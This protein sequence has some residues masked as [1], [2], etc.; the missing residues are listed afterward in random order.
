MNKQ[1]RVSAAIHGS[2]VDYV[3]Y[4][5]WY[6]FGTQFMPGE[7]AADLVTGFYERFDLDFIKVMNDYS[8]P[9]PAGLDRIRT[10][11]DWKRMKPAKPTEGGF[12][13]QL[14]LLNVVAQRVKSEAFFV[15]TIFDPFYVARRT[16]K[17]IIFDLLRSHPEEFKL[18]LEVITESL[19]NYV[20]AVLDTGAAG[21][22]LAVNGASTDLLS[23]EEFQ[24]FVKPY[25]LQVLEAAQ[26][27]GILNIVHIHGNNIL[28]DDMLDYPVHVLSW[29]H[30]NTPPSFRDARQKTD[31]CFMGG[32]N[33]HLTSKFHPDELEAQV[34]TA[35]QDTNGEKLIL[36]SGCSLPTDMPVELIDIISRAVRKQRL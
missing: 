18:G 14:K 6:H 29:E 30:L 23:K 26:E 3:P 22:Y 32:I 5:M 4:S 7:K 9:L 33:E 21:I 15:D 24:E 2:Q 10:L 20:K 34:E 11:D 36:A 19:R 12:A 25:D 1:E 28:F 35:L 17:D 13:E 8:Y 31:L 27:K 16:A